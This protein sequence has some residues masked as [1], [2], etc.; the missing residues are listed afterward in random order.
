MG[1]V[2]KLI[3]GAGGLAAAATGAALVYNA[4]TTP[5]GM[6]PASDFA[7]AEEFVTLQDG[8]RSHYR[9]ALP[10]EAE[11]K[12]PII[13]L[14]GLGGWV[15]SWRHNLGVLG[16]HNPTYALDRL[17]FGLSDKPAITYNL[18]LYCNQVMLFLNHLGLQRV[19][20]VGHSAGAPVAIRVATRFPTQVAGLVLAAPAGLESPPPDQA[21]KLFARTPFATTLAR[22]LLKNR[23]LSKGLLGIS[24]ANPSFMSEE[25]LVN[26]ELP[27][28]TEGNE[29]TLRGLLR[30][31]NPNAGIVEQLP[32]VTAPTLVIY[33]T[34]DRVVKPANAARFAALIPHAEAD[35]IADAGHLLMEEQADTFNR[36]VLNFAARLQKEAS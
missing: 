4:A 5:Q 1:I 2:S 23:V 11:G 21:V 10:A 36:A 18:D 3:K 30:S 32:Q 16:Q 7:P 14:H 19:I 27:L 15:Y 25:V 13:L 34:A 6:R 29:N 28:Q 9:S 22:L 35:V 31:G 17:G 12:L 24:Y 8:W 33:G 26:Y 20:L